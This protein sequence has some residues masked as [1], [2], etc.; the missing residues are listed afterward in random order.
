MQDNN[1]HI[2]NFFNTQLFQFESIPDLSLDDILFDNH[3]V[4]LFFN[5]LLSEDVSFDLKGLPLLY[6]QNNLDSYLK[7]EL[8]EQSVI[9]DQLTYYNSP[10]IYLKRTIGLM[11]S[12][13]L[14]AFFVHLKNFRNIDNN[15]LLSSNLSNQNVINSI[16]LK[17]KQKLDVIQNSINN[18]NQFLN[19]K[20]LN[21]VNA[22]KVAFSQNFNRPINHL[23]EIGMNSGKSLS[24]ES[25]NIKK[26]GF[27]KFQNTQI[28]EKDLIEKS[29]KKQDFK[30]PKIMRS[31]IHF[32]LETGFSQDFT[33]APKLLTTDVHKDALMNFNQMNKL[34]RRGVSNAMMVGVD[35]HP[36]WLLRFGVQVSQTQRKL[37]FTY[38]YNQI[39]VY[40]SLNNLLGYLTL[41]PGS[42]QIT[43]DV[44]DLKQ[45]QI[46]VPFH[47]FY[48]LKAAQNWSIWSGIGLE[49]VISK[50]H[51]GKL[52]NF[53]L[54]QLSVFKSV[55]LNQFN[56]SASILF[57][58]HLSPSLA[59][60]LN[61]A[62]SHSKNYFNIHHINYQNSQLNTQLRIG[63][64]YT[65][66]IKTK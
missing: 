49:Y 20:D 16:L 47:V 9:P 65:P 17:Q 32:A 38:D 42:S 22:N 25:F 57:K 46:A 21:Q 41:P 11:L 50:T 19:E 66:I 27:V 55:N 48:K 63:I 23:K 59:L 1:S 36:N 3:P 29:I 24:E 34:N 7:S 35:V 6:N 13:I 53:E 2:D 45:T 44:I 51:Q 14:V 30:K 10:I 26:Q 40:D 62:M 43:N 60:N 61:A 58:Y 52:F 37:N 8:Q 12:V 18:T 54:E 64:N 56:P 28:I 39:P 31:P 15:H 4:D 5:Q 33:Y